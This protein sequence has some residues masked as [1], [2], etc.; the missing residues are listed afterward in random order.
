MNRNPSFTVGS[1][2]TIVWFSICIAVLLLSILIAYPQPTFSDDELKALTFAWTKNGSMDQTQTVIVITGVT[3]G[4]G[5]ALAIRL[6][7]LGLGTGIV[8][9]GIGRS[10]SKLD[11]LGRQLQE[12]DDIMR[13]NMTSSKREFIP[14]VAD[15][16]DLETVVAAAKE[17]KAKFSKIDVLVNNAGIHL[18]GPD[19]FGG[20]P[21]RTKQGYELAFGVNYL[22]HFLLTRALLPE[23]ESSD[24][25]RIVQ[26]SSS[27]HWMADGSELSTKHTSHVG[28]PFASRGDINSVLQR[29]RSYANSKLAQIL[30]ARSL[31]QLYNHDTNVD[32]EN[33]SRLRAISVCPGWVSTGMTQSPMDS[34]FSLL[35][36]HAD[37]YGLRSTFT[38]IFGKLSTSDDF[39]TNS[40]LFDYMPMAFIHQYIWSS[41][42]S[43]FFLV[44]DITTW[45]F[46]VAL[47]YLQKV[48]AGGD[49]LSHPSKSSPE[50]YDFD[51]QEDLYQWSMDVTA[52]Y[53]I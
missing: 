4:L 18:E 7:R 15:F 8:V 43:K 37:G 3:S 25:A 16:S 10:R 33:S 38:A 30:H 12:M 28:I 6:Y 46:A 35:A 1:K 14:V 41:S 40:K 2:S 50:T 26:I 20:A 36:F 32:G 45:S 5:R 44:R 53:L 23:L 13:S 51:L 27:F 42:I 19:I 22:S 47:M 52:P 49:V 34:V 39:L 11:D 48:F 24:H 21:V 29:F 9:V 31:N 17:I